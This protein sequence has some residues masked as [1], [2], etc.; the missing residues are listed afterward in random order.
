M[1]LSSKEAIEL[2]LD[3]LSTSI[4]F[5]KRSIS[6]SALLGCN[7][8]SLLFSSWSPRSVFCTDIIYLFT[9]LYPSLKFLRTVEASWVAILLI[10]MKSLSTRLGFRSFPPSSFFFTT[11]LYLRICCSSPRDDI[12]DICL[13]TAGGGLTWIFI[14]FFF[15]GA[16]FSILSNLIYSWG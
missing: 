1:L 10:V 15:L 16:E 5:Y 11:M 8:L 12:T 13:L 2:S 9:S 4:P 6:R 3:R 7:L 14:D